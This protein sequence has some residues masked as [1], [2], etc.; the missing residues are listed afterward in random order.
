MSVRIR[1]LPRWCAVAVLACLGGTA[2]TVLQA[3]DTPQPAEFAW[4]GVLNLPTGASLARVDLPVQALLRMQ[5]S[6]ASD[7]RVFNA[8]GAVV[9]FVLVGGMALSSATPVAHTAA[10][11]AYAL[12]ANGQASAGKAQ[13]GSVSVRV[14]TGGKAG[15]A[16]V[17]WDEASGSTTEAQA[18]AQPLQAALFDMRKEAQAVDALE[19]SLSLPHNALVPFT[20]A[21]STDL[22]EWTPVPTQGPLFQFDGADAPANLTLELGQPLALQGRYLRLTWEGQAGVAV[23]SVTGRVPTGPSPLT[24]VRAAL[25]PGTPEGNNSLSWNLPFATPIAALHL[26]ALRNNSLVPVRIMGRNEPSLPWRTLAGAVVYRLDGVGQGSANAPTSLHGASL[27]ALRVEAS[28]GMVL[29]EGGLQASVE[30]APLQVAFLASGTGPF[31]LAVGRAQTATAAVDASL[32]GGVAPTR[33]GEL[34]LATVAAVQELPDSAL[35]GMAPGWLP[36]GTSMRSVLL[37]AVLGAGVLAL[38]GVAYSLLR[39]IGRKQ[40]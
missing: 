14:D 2:P 12:F 4:R 18:Q 17:R 33:L 24:P 9:P 21:T 5:S 38:G 31:T 11:K 6:S 20:V 1:K 10:Y 19:L 25:P 15:N 3:A 28:Q 22:N 35:A 23:Q 36:A 13:R 37:W 27:R 34:P 7:V 32:L 40:A 30:F 26:Q 29:P 39:Q 8:S 16:W